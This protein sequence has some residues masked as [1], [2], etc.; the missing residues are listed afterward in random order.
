MNIL[1]VILSL[2]V[3]APFSSSFSKIELKSFGLQAS[4]ASTGR[5]ETYA[6]AY[7]VAFSQMPSGVTV[8]N[9][10]VIKGVNGNDWVVTLFWRM[11]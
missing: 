8:Y 6:G 9:K 4:G 3:A 11:K 7:S 5:G 2:L 1:K 10:G